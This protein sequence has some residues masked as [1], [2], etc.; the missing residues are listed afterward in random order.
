MGERTVFRD[1]SYS[2]W[3]RPESIQ[4]FVGAGRARSLCQIDED[5]TYWVEYCYC[6]K[7]LRKLLIPVAC[8]ETA[9]DYPSTRLDKHTRDQTKA[10]R[11]LARASGYP[12][13]VVLYKQSASKTIVD[14]RGTEVPD[15]ESFAVQC[16]Y[17][18]SE[19]R[20]YINELARVSRSE[21][22]W[23]ILTPC[24][25]AHYIVL[26]H[27]QVER[28]Y[29]ARPLTRRGQRRLR[30]YD[31]RL[32]LGDEETQPSLFDETEEASA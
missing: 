13:F 29:H 23:R 8:V 18:P 9:M 6:R 25:Y 11:N 21:P 5:V 1:Q 7:K 28:I 3:H 16:L 2:V 24:E 22:P 12:F 26:L 17:D 14:S 4:R 32:D 30:S 15:I 19:D 27:D 20:F 31:P 10:H